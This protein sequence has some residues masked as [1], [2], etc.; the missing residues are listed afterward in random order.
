MAEELRRKIA[1]RCLLS[2]RMSQLLEMIDKSPISPTIDSKRDGLLMAYADSMVRWVYSR[3]YRNR[4][5][6]L[7]NKTINR[8]I[9]KILSK[10][11][12]LNETTIKSLEKIIDNN[13]SSLSS[14]FLN[15][16]NKELRS[17]SLF[18]VIAVKDEERY[19]PGFF[20]H[21]RDY[22]DGFVVLDDGSIDETP[23]IIKKE[24][25]VISVMTN[26][27]HGPEDWDEKGNR[28]RLLNEARRLGGE[29]VLFCDAD[30]RFEVGFLRELRGLAQD[31]LSQRKGLQYFRLLW[32]I[33]NF[34]KY[35]IKF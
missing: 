13:S 15:Y 27:P 20:N 34:K 28:I 16:S 32:K 25:K 26:P 4:K 10:N 29:V 18:A 31:C 22:V 23:N 24:S 2:I 30:E 19:L 6:E 21:L 7:K 14:S 8:I 35:I 1:G 17:V 9:Q 33:T 5:F 11:N 3:D 12:N